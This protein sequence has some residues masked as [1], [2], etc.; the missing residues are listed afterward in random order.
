M[1]RALRSFLFL[2][3]LPAAC[4]KNE[5]APAAGSAAASASAAPRGNGKGLDD[6]DNDPKLTALGEEAK[7]CRFNDKTG[8]GGYTACP[9]FQKIKSEART[10]PKGF[11]TLLNWLEDESPA[12]RQAAAHALSVGIFDMKLF[13]DCAA[14]QRVFDAMQKETLDVNASALGSPLARFAEACEQNGD[15][16]LGFVKDKAFAKPSGRQE[17]IRLIGR[18]FLT[19]PGVFEAVGDVAR[20]ESEQERVRTSAVYALGRVPE[21]KKP[22][23][24]EI[25]RA[26]LKGKSPSL[27]QDS[28]R[29][30]ADS[31]VGE[32][33]GDVVELAK[34]DVAGQCEGGHYLYA[35]SSYVSRKEPE[36]DKKK[37]FAVA[38]TAV[39]KKTCRWTTRTAALR[40]LKNGDAPNWKALAEKLAKDKEGQNKYVADE[41]TRLLNEAKAPKM[42]PMG[43][44]GPGGPGGPGGPPGPGGPHGMGGPP[45]MVGRPPPPPGHP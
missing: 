14:M 42:P 28:A 38:T 29:V 13:A 4:A 27:S 40:L 32:A 41:A 25:L 30:L 9:A 37:A 21:E 19:R 35:L 1:Q 31:R 36:V 26:V 12:V 20:D 8:F 5:P 15:K 10:A 11:A 34:T 43:Q 24:V 3:L 45:G 39:N 17:F 7:K 16:L 33:F 44:P 18:K 2:A 22:A 6:P 23:A